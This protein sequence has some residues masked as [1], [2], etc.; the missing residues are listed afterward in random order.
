MT[1]VLD[2]HQEFISGRRDGWADLG[3]VK[4]K[5]QATWAAGDFGVIGAT[6]QIVGESLCEAVDLRAGSQVLDVATGTGN[7][8]LAAARRWCDVTGI[9]FVATLLERGRERARAERLDVRFIE[10]DVESLPFADESFDFVLSTYGCMF[11]PNH[12]RTAQEMLR[13]V[14]P[15]GR[16]G[17]ANWTPEGFLGALFV[18][19]GR[20]LPPPPGQA[21]P[22]RWGTPKGIRDLFGDHAHEIAVTPRIFNFR[23]RS[24]QHWVE[25]FRSF[26][27][28]THKAFAALGVDQQ[29]A[30]EEDLLALLGRWNVAKDQGLVV[31]GEYLEVV[32]QKN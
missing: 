26:Y 6:L 2:C 29:R 4:T 24:A 25:V 1:Q 27:G 11:A 9:D 7:A 12:E 5:Q 15:G 23:Y 17:M 3:P 14:R 28:P 16:I 22:M 19:I 31:P 8:A 32:V 30:L 20:H 10:A 13:V 21:S 18:T